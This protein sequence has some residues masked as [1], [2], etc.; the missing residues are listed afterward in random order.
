MVSRG[1]PGY[2]NWAEKNSN[3]IALVTKIIMCCHGTFRTLAYLI[4]AAY[5]KLCQIYK[6]MRHIENTGIIRTVYLGI[7]G[8]IQQ[9]SAMVKYIE[10]Y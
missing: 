10:G 8:N 2:T 7:F 9:Y 1:A 5:S 4:P 6:M 3:M